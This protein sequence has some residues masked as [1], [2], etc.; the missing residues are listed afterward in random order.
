MGHALLFPGDVL[1]IYAELGLVL[2]A[3]GRVPPRVLL[4]LALALLAVFPLGRAANAAVTPSA[5]VTERDVDLARAQAVN[6]ELRN[7]HPYA[8]GSVMDVMRANAQVIPANPL[9]SPLGAESGLGFF[10]MFLLGLYA[11]KREIFLDIDRHIL[12]IRL[13]ALWGLSLG[14]A[15]MVVERAISLGLGYDVEGESGPGPGLGVL[16]DLRLAPEDQDRH[17]HGDHHGDGDHGR[18]R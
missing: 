10:A 3:F 13:G 11:G 17:H 2:L 1:M 16:R 15:A 14:I 12:L 4:G 5:V 7:T 9:G 8:V 6:E 18:H